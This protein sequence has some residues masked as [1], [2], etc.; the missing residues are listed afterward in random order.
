LAPKESGG[1]SN[2]YVI[3]LYGKKGTLQTPVDSQTLTPNWDKII[4]KKKEKRKTI[5]VDQARNDFKFAYD[6]KDYQHVNIKFICMNKAA[7]K[8][9]YMGSFEIH[10]C[11][12]INC[13]TYLLEDSNFQESTVAPEETKFDT[14]KHE[15]KKHKVVKEHRHV[16][17]TLTIS[18]TFYD[19]NGSE[20]AYSST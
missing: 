1:T 3:V 16:S 7:L 11:E 19:E 2:P 20:V 4:S 6:E 9:D 18:V 8:D 14:K 5:T 13:K 17:G 15:S 10:P 12:T